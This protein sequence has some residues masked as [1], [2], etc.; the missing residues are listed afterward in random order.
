MEG[1]AWLKYFTDA[2]EY[3]ATKTGIGENVF[4]RNS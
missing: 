1:R 2:D 3:G 4:V